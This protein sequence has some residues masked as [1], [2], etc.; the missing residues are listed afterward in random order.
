M[1]KSPENDNSEAEQGTFAGRIVAVPDDVRYVVF[2]L[3][4]IQSR[5]PGAADG[6][7]AALSGYLTSPRLASPGAPK[8]VE[9]AHYVDSDGYHNDVLMA[10]WLDVESYRAWAAQ[11]EVAV[12]WDGLPQDPASDVGFWREVLMPDKD[13]FEFAGASERKAASANFLEL[14]DVTQPPAALGPP[15]PASGAA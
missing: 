10:Y 15:V 1:D 4:G 6:H 5:A 13:R 2:V 3:F 12:W 9:R 14:R 11:A 7:L 8:L